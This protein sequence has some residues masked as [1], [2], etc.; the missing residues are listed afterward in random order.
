MRWSFRSLGQSH[1][2]REVLGLSA[3]AACRIDPCYCNEGRNTVFATEHEQ[4]YWVEYALEQLNTV[5]QV[6]TG[7]DGP[8]RSL[9]MS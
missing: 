2:V 6:A 4:Q 7:F 8:D 3:C 5:Q 9:V 1:W